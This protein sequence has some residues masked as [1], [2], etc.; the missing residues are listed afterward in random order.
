MVEWNLRYVKYFFTIQ[1][2]F[3]IKIEV[4]GANLE[5]AYPASKVCHELHM[6]QT[7]DL[8]EGCWKKRV[9]SKAYIAALHHLL[10]RR[11][12]CAD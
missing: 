2:I 3:W 9:G 1:P 10:L 5:K 4:V 8:I 11:L 12:S 7:R 6:M